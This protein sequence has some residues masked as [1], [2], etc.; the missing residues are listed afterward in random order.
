M[1]NIFNN[2]KIKTKENTESQIKTIVNSDN[3]EDLKL[4]EK[5]ND[6][7]NQLVFGVN[8]FEYALTQKKSKIAHYFNELDS[9]I[10][11]KLLEN[12]PCD[13]SL[14]SKEILLKNKNIEW[15][16]RTVLFFKDELISNLD[17]AQ[18]I[19]ENLSSKWKLTDSADCEFLKYSFYKNNNYFKQKTIEL[20][21]KKPRELK[22]V[23][24]NI[25]LYET[26]SSLLKEKEFRILIGKQLI[27]DIFQPDE[28]FQLETLNR[29]IK[30][31]QGDMRIVENNHDGTSISWLEKAQTQYSNTIILKNRLLSFFDDVTPNNII[32]K[33]KKP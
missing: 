4:Y 14:I 13:F 31:E 15:T 12:L 18:E 27:L 2:I 7:F 23:L 19:H 30:R 32:E 1:S 21:Q 24:K 6:I 17:K 3:L 9:P 26:D 11:A 28:D 33:R 20:L 5:T 29:E 10:S 22:K 8:L 25:F 16:S